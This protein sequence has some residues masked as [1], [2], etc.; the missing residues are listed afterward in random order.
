MD[1]LQT[2]LKKDLIDCITWSFNTLDKGKHDALI[3][4]TLRKN[5]ILLA[6]LTDSRVLK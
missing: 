5:L 1:W 4:N 2:V 6:K 3:V